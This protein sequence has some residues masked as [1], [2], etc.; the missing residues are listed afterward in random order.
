MLKNLSYGRQWINE[1]DIAEVVNIL[2]GDWLTQGPAVDAFEKALADYLGVNFV[3]TF[4]N[5]TAALHGAV[6][7]AGIGH[8]DRVLTTP[9]TFAATANAALYA[10]AEPVFADINLGTVCLDPIEAE[11]KLEE[12][13]QK[14]KAIIPVSYAGYP[15][16]IEAFRFMAADYGAV[17]IE[18]ACHS[19][20]GSRG[21]HKIGFSADMTAFSFHPVKHITTA[22]GGAVATNNK[23]YAKRLKLFRSHG[24]TR[25]PS[26][27]L[28]S[29]N[30]PWHS[31]M[32]MLGYNYRLSDLNCALGLS[33]MK[34]LDSFIERRR[35][36]SLLYRSL[37]AGIP[38]L[39][40]PPSDE[41][42]A[43][44]LFAIRVLEKDR[45]ALYNHLAENGI[46]LQVHY[47]PVHLH[48]YYKK[49]FGYKV[50]DYPKAERFARSAISLPMYPMM[51]DEDAIRV[52]S[53]IKEFFGC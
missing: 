28:E 32:Q 3:V 39:H 18:D 27:F 9:M 29:T 34:R 14:I 30:A 48:P 31:E 15:F 50:G 52:A 11:K 7:A 41:G 4:A 23:G 10:G 44:H 26:E 21:A 2:K 22:E 43:Y 1:D 42:H 33:Q 8:G 46:R 40:Q 19:L 25:D 24:I 38:G 12:L 51:K 37:L 53:C 5:G 45:A 49:R 6:S 20:G 13:P 47:E 36:I 16:D 17:L 35:E